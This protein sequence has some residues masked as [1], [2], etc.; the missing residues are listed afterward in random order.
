MQVG[1][2]VLVF[3]VGHRFSRGNRLAVEVGRTRTVL[4]VVGSIALIGPEFALRFVDGLLHTDS[5]ARDAKCIADSL[6]G[7]REPVLRSTSLESA[8][9]VVADAVGNSQTVVVEHLLSPL[10]R[11]H[12]VACQ[13][14]Q[15]GRE[16]VAATCAELL[17]HARCPVLRTAFV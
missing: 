12:H 3:A 6:G 8:E 17:Q 5:I 11:L 7:E 15:V 16:V 4:N 2:C 10:F 14:G 13:R 1:W 9:I